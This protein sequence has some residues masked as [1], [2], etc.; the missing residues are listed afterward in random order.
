MRIEIQCKSERTTPELKLA[1]VDRCVYSIGDS[2]LST[3]ATYVCTAQFS[4]KYTMKR[5]DLRFTDFLSV[6][7]EILQEDQIAGCYTPPGHGC[8]Q[9]N[10]Q[11][12]GITWAR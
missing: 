6:V 5:V 7:F 8:L 10:L 1:V 11:A 2:L 9:G 4:F 12:P 3:H